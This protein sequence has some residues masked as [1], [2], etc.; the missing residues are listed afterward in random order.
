MSNETIEKEDQELEELRKQIEQKAEEEKEQASKPVEPEPTH[1]EPATSPASD[2][3]ASDPAPVTPNTSQPEQSQTATGKDDPTEW[4][5]KKGIETYD[6][7]VRALQQKEIEFHK[8]NQ[9]GH[10]GYRDINGD[11]PVVQPAWQPAPQMG[12]GYQQ[13]PV[14]MPQP[15]MN[16]R[17]I[18]P[19]YPQLAPEDVERVMPL[20]MDAAEVISNRKMAALRQEFGGQVSE[21]QRTTMRN[22]ELMQLMQDPAFRDNRV[23]R[24]V[25]AVLDSDPSIFQR[26]RTPYAYAYEKALANM[27]R[28]QLQQGFDAGKETLGL[29]PPVTAGGGNGSANTAPVKITEKMFDSWTPEEQKAFLNSN[30][31]IIPKR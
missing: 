13:P 27:T 3:P 26:E 25:H 19:Y 5:K 14:Y 16:P 18:A 8:R 10:P 9:A 31:R 28:K 23:Q 6:D 22:N 7:A 2:V 1:P 15:R 30:G 24:E 20:V 21:I 17:E 4:A 29:K 11:K 12:Y